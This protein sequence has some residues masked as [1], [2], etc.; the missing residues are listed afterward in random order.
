MS[1]MYLSI[2]III[3]FSLCIS[4]CFFREF[5]TF[6]PD[7]LQNYI[8]TTDLSLSNYLQISPFLSSYNP[9]LKLS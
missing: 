8:I 1:T 7:N 3:Y 2:L 4:I 5:Y 9:W 6:F